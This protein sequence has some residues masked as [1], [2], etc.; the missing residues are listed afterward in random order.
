MKIVS[1]VKFQEVPRTFMV[2]ALVRSRSGIFWKNSEDFEAHSRRF[3]D[4]DRKRVLAPLYSSS[5]CVKVPTPVIML[6]T[7]MLFAFW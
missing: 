2:S 1:V 7:Y 6:S 4:A 3:I 5:N